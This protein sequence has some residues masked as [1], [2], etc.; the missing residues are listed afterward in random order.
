MS[1]LLTFYAADLETF[2][3]LHKRMTLAQ[4]PEEASFVQEQLAS[5]PQ[6]DFSLNFTIPD[7]T[8]A[9]CQAMISQGLPV[10]SSSLEL[11]G[12]PLWYDEAASI[13]QLPDTFIQALT[14]V[15]ELGLKHIAEQWV[16]SFLPVREKTNDEVIIFQ[17]V[18]TA[19]SDLRAVAIFVLEHHLSLLL[20]L[21]W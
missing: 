4:T 15:S 16:N 11:F 9:L 18:I 21:V 3:N 6:A 2:I 13:H 20:R 5:Y 7:H 10:P 8:D 17:N 1:L 19:L 14:Q 12:K